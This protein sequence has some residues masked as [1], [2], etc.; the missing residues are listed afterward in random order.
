MPI[1]RACFDV[2]GPVLEGRAK[3]TNLPWIVDAGSLKQEFK[4]QAVD[5]LNDLEAA[6]RA[7]PI[8]KPYELRTLNDGTAARYGA[9][10][11]IAP[12]TGL[13][14]G[15][16][17]WNDNHY[18]AYPSEGGHTDFAPVDSMQVGLLAYLQKRFDHVSFERVCSGSGIP[19]IYDYLLDSGYAPQ[20]PEVAE[21]VVGA[22]DR[23][24][25]IV[26]AGMNPA[27][28]CPLCAATLDL[29]VS[30]LA[31]ESSNLA[32]KLL[33]TGG[34]YVGGGI[35]PRIMS[36]LEDGRFMR[37]FKNKGRFA[38]LLKRIP[39][40]VIVRQVALLGTAHYGLDLVDQ[41]RTA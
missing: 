34:V 9:I 37:V 33:A 18:D 20:T 40:H 39:V 27:R 2:A 35:P 3:I 24:P 6:A 32:L 28:P 26:E 36:R 31:A 38:E 41:T 15:F 7:I 5:L 8:L 4:L 29:F 10:A 14:E 21:Q 25:I 17:I 23:T 11:V 16:L 22:R 13:G 19:N 30:I 1:E 12:G